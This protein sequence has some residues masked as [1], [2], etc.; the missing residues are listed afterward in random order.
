DVRLQMLPVTSA[1]RLAQGTPVHVHIG[2]AHRVAHVVPLESSAIGAGESARAQLVFDAPMC[3][4]PGDRFIVRDAGAAR[5]I[6][7]GIVLDPEAPRRKRRAAERLRRLDALE[8]TIADGDVAALLLEAAL[9]IAMTGLVR[10][11]GLPAERIPLPSDARVVDTSD[12]PY[13]VL[14]CHWHGLRARALEALRDF[15]A[16]LPDEAGPDAARLRRIAFPALSPALCTALVDE[17]VRDGEIVRRGAWLQTPEHEVT[18]SDADRSLAERLAPR[19]AAGRFNPPWVR[20]L[21]SALG[22]PEDRVRDV[23]RKQVRQGTVCQV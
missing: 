7:G 10:T 21:A 22:E 9:G 6:G 8:K 1:P 19:I 2:T 16:A 23:L 13:V 14:D 11:A 17:L 20:D 5:T 18:L 15:H 3:A 4:L 12:Q